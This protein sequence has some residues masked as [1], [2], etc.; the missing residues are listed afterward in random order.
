MPSPHR[1]T[2]QAPADRAAGAG[3]RPAYCFAIQTAADPGAMTRVLEP[4]AKRGLVPSRCHAVLMEPERQELLIDLQVA[5]LAPEDGDQIARYLR[6]QVL[7][8]SVLTCAN[9]PAAALGRIA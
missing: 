4:F 6:Q 1:P 7:V 5:G 8:I 9:L 2:P 3:P